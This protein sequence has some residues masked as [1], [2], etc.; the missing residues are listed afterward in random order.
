MVTLEE[1]K[2]IWCQILGTEE[3]GNDEN[4]YD[5]GGN[6]L[7]LLMILNEISK[8]YGC[9]LPT[10]DV[11]QYDTVRKMAACLDKQLLGS[12]AIS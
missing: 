1:I 12:G 8:T 10:S 3:I 2:E 4:F 9:D 7:L 6:S 11:Y 5:I